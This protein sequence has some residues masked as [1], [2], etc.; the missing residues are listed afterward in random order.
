[1]L[2]ST[3]TS[4]FN[5]NVSIPSSIDWRKKIAVNTVK[6]QGRFCASGYAFSAVAAIEGRYKIKTGTLYTLSEQQIVDCGSGYAPDR[7]NGC[8]GWCAEWVF[9]YAQAYGMETQA[10]YPYV[11]AERNC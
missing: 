8:D 10:N 4:L 9:Y 6:N 3:S 2:N 11:A 7:L 1:L 5:S